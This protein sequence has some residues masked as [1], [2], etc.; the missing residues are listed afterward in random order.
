MWDRYPTKDGE[1]INKN[2][3]NGRIFSHERNERPMVAGGNDT[4][5][6]LSGN[7]YT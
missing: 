2:S 7:V 3:N 1:R 4:R 5:K 6:P